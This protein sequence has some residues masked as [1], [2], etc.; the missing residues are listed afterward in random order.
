MELC[1]RSFSRNSESQQ[2]CNSQ[3]RNEKSWFRN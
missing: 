2:R 3:V 1:C